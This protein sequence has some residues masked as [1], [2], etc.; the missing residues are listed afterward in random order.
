MDNKEI[1]DLKIT[2]AKLEERVIT[3]TSVLEKLS[4]RIETLYITREEFTPVKLVVYG[5]CSTI[6]AFVVSKILGLL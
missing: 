3:L 6:G 1:V 4:R 2:L 5:I